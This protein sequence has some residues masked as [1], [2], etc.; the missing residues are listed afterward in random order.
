M[1]CS[2]YLVVEILYVNSNHPRVAIVIRHFFLAFS[3]YFQL[4]WQL[5]RTGGWEDSPV[6]LQAVADA[7]CS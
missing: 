7:S 5:T 2:N 6:E 3:L 4:E 1:D